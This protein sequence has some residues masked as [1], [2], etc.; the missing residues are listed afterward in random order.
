MPAS[1]QA[2]ASGLRAK[3]RDL[4]KGLSEYIQA[5]KEEGLPAIE[6]FRVKRNQFEKEWDDVVKANN[7]CL[8]LLN[9]ED[10]VEVGKVEDLNEALDLVR[11]IKGLLEC[12]ESDILRKS[13]DLTGRKNVVALENV[14]TV[15]SISEDAENVTEKEGSFEKVHTLHMTESPVFS[16]SGI[17]VE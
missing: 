15:S 5:I 8:S 12:Y 17:K 6:E 3:R 7:N 11:D 2:A 1:F 10:D 14:D 13:A 9:P 16:G 4:S